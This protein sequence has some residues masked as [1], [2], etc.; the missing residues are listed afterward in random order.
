M[1]QVLASLSARL[2]RSLM[3]STCSS[4]ATRLS[5]P[6]GRKPALS[7]GCGVVFLVAVT[8]QKPSKP[9][10]GRVRTGCPLSRGSFWKSHS[11]PGSDKESAGRP[12]SPSPLRG[13]GSCGVELGSQAAGDGRTP[14]QGWP[15]G[16]TGS[17]QLEAPPG[18]LLLRRAS[19]RRVF[20]PR[21]TRRGGDK[22]QSVR[23]RSRH[24]GLL[25]VVGSASPEAAPTGCAAVTRVPAWL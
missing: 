1:G 20:T 12:G 18:N 3:L 11:L 24:L 16:A 21:Q 22:G 17:G 25:P 15:H 23:T 6:F 13:A 7:G 8:W 4:S 2:V 9:E 14:A 5:C 10:K 19:L